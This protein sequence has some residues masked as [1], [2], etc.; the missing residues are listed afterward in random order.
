MKKRY[1]NPEVNA[2]QVE[3]Q[4]LL[5]G[6]SIVKM[7]NESTPADAQGEVLSRKSIWDNLD[8]ED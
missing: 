6:S 4:E 1:I 2:L 5:E 3:L 8:D 7:A